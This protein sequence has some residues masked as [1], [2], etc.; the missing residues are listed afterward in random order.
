MHKLYNKFLNH[1]LFCT[2][3][4]GSCFLVR[5]S[6]AKVKMNHTSVKRA[7]SISRL[8]LTD[9]SECVFCVCLWMWVCVGGGCLMWRG[10]K[11]ALEVNFFGSFLDVFSL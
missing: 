10:S 1:A 3:N 6:L 4:S 7:T 5:K 9:Y 8:L 11:K 2:L